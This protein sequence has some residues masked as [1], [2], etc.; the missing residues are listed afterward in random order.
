MIE[1]CEQREVR[2]LPGKRSMDPSNENATQETSGLSVAQKIEESRRDVL[3]LSLR[4]SLLNFRPSRRLGVE[5]LDE[6]SSEIFRILVQKRRIMYFLPAPKEKSE[7]K[8]DYKNEDFPFEL[9]TLLAEPEV[10]SD[11]PADRHVDNKLQTS[12]ER[13]TLNRRLIET[14][15]HA[16]SSIEEQGVNTLYLALGLLRWYE[17]D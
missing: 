6:L 17:S 8:T 9:L 1:A 14:F 3:D 2:K 12:Q 10:E 15:R 7:P 11:E 4:N 13:A 16:R 5:V